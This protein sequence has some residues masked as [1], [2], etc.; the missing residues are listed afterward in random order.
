MLPTRWVKI[1][2]YLHSQPFL[3]ITFLLNLK[4]LTIFVH[5]PNV[6]WLSLIFCCVCQ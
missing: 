3:S 4:L 1:S 5:T 6:L 2:I